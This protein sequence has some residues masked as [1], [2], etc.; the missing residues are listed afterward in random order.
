MDLSTVI[1]GGKLIYMARPKLPV[2]KKLVV[3]SLRVT[4]QQKRAIKA[5]GGTKWVREL[6]DQSHSDRD[7][8]GGV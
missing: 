3:V 6:L 4:P 1:F 2:G 7:A 5:N 8:R